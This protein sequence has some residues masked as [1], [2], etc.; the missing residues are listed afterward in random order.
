MAEAGEQRRVVRRVAREYD[1]S[2]GLGE[3][4]SKAFA[5]KHPAHR[6]LVVLAEPAVDVNRADLRVE[7]RRAHQRRDALRRLERQRRNVLAVVDGEVGLAVV[8]VRSERAARNGGED[9]VRDGVQAGAFFAPRLGIVLEAP[10]QPPAG[11]EKVEGAVLPDYGV[12]RPHARDVVTPAR[13]PAG[14]RHRDLAGAPQS[15]EG[16]VRL[17]SELAL[18]GQGVVDI[19]EQRFHASR[20]EL[21]K[22]LHRLNA[23]STRS[24]AR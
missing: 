22:R 5:E 20:V 10:L 23:A 9:A 14:H 8:L 6:Q 15:L 2:L 18:G 21:G 4:H 19:E 16:V 7:A 12:D 17:G 1:F 3:I 24:R 11:V 13:R